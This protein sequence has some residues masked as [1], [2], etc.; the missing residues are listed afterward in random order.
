MKVIFF[1]IDGTLLDHDERVPK[2]TKEALALTKERGHKRILC[3]GRSRCAV[4]QLMEKFDFDGCV[5]SAGAYVEYQEQVVNREMLE[6]TAVHRLVDFLESSESFYGLQCKEYVVCPMEMKKEYE[7]TF[8]AGGNVEDSLQEEEKLDDIAKTFIFVDDIR[9]VRQ[10]E[11]AFYFGA[12]VGVEEAGRI[13]GEGFDVRPASYNMPDANHGEV[14]INGVTKSFG[15][16]KL[17]DFLGVDRMD[18]IAFGDGYN[19]LEMLEFAG[20]GVAMG[21]A[22]EELKKVADYVTEPVD[23]DGIYLAMKRLNLI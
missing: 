19:D 23:Q 20:V 9:A 5:C 18:T 14:S 12:N 17:L 1:D 13:L 11:K 16:Q 7:K 8:G 15:M 3:S 6:T 4:K 10:A 21:N 22:V 2:S